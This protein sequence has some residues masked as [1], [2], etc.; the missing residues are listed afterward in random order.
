MRQTPPGGIIGAEIVTKC[1]ERSVT[2][3]EYV[4]FA[5]FR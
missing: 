5:L 1:T 4:G 2:R 3:G